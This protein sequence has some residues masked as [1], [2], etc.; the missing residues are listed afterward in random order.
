MT[1]LVAAIL[2]APS[3]P[4]MAQTKGIPEDAAAAARLHPSELMMKALP[5]LRSGRG[6]EATFWFY[7]GQLRWRSS[8]KEN[9]QQD[10]TGEPAL[11]SSLM[12]TVGSQVNE[13][14]FGD[15]PQLQ[16]TIDAVL[17]WDRRNPD[18]SLDQTVHAATRQG[19][20]G[21]RVEIGLETDRIRSERTSRG[22]PNR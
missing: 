4:A 16:R 21:L 1:G 20:E 14:A 8:L 13:W 6:E 7:A 18:P 10:P 3:F 19:L 9:T 15:I 11:F 12:D 5:L 2:L 22:L 17:E